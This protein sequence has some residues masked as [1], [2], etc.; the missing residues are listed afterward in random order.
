[1]M[2]E[3]LHPVIVFICWLFKNRENMRKIAFIILFGLLILRTTLAQAVDCPAIVT[4]ALN[5]VDAACT[6][7]GRN[8]VCYGNIVLTATPRAGV[9]NL[10]FNKAGDQASVTDIQKL[11]LSS[12]NMADN[13]WG[14]ALMELQANL[15]DTTPGQN[16]KFLLF[17]DV[18]ID[19]DVKNATE[20]KLTTIRNVNVRLRPTTSGSVMSSLKSGQTVTATG[21]LDDNS[22]VQIRVEGDAR[23]AGW[24]SAD[25]LKGDTSKLN[26][27]N[28][29]APIWGP[30]QSF[31]FKTGIG[32]RPCA[33]APDSGILIQTP[34]GSARVILNIND[35]QI[36]LGSTIYIQAQ[37]N[38]V[39]TVTV[40]EGQAILTSNGQT[41]I[42]PA[43][44][45]S[46]VK[47]DAASKAAGSPSFP[48]PYDAAPL[49]TLPLNLSIFTP[50]TIAKPL[51]TVQIQATVEAVTA[52]ASDNGGTPRSG[53]WIHDEVVTVNDN[54][55]DS[56]PL[57]KRNKG[58]IKLTFSQDGQTVVF[59]NGWSG[60]Y[61]LAREGDNVYGGKSG[62]I[63]FIF[64]FTS[65]TTYNYSHVG[66][67]GDINNGGCH[68]EL[69]GTGVFAR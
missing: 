11:Q 58:P 36:N 68:H 3:I 46:Q 15:P 40:V 4:A 45:Y 34:K 47:L 2:E 14:V 67:F 22:W 39:M 9:T 25:F 30:M 52:P 31:Y 59:D 44:T 32:D 18:Q 20:I 7:T 13:S 29:S 43:G 37:P 17:G 57:G 1:M 63:T 51:T 8:Q 41:Q 53:T 64:T 10:I 28:P 23:E 48:Q 35:V 69:V 27:I 21:R 24:V 56:E 62:G 60:P 38:N 42:V 5:A 16:V 50:I 12:M 49:Q 19:N 66:I 33:Q 55:G 61:T 65:R 6:T 54:C 26:V